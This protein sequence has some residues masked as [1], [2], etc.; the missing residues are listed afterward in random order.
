MLRTLRARLILSH[1]LPT[2]IIVPLIGILLVFILETQVLRPALAREMLGEARILAEIG[3]FQPEI[4]QDAAIA[5]Q[6]LSQ[7]R[8]Q[9][10]S[11]MMIL[12]ADGRLL[13]S[14]EALDGERIGQVLDSPGLDE[15]RAGETVD[16]ID[17][18]EGLQ[19]QAID[20]WVPVFGDGNALV[21]IIRISYRFT[22]IIE[23]LMRLRYLI[24]GVLLVGM[25]GGAFLGYVLAISLNEP[26][27][28]VTFTIYNLARGDFRQP[29]P[30]QGPEE[31]RLQLQAVNFLVARLHELEESRKQLLA[32][33]VHELGRP[34]GALRV[35]LQAL[36]RGARDDPALR[37]ELL[38]SMDLEMERLQYLLEELSHLHDQVLGSLELNLQPLVLSDWLPKVLRPWRELAEE[39]N[40]TWQMDV[41]A[42]LPPIYAD[43]QRLAQALGNLVSNAI[44]YTPVGGA[45]T[46]NAGSAN[47]EI[48]IRVA[49]TG[50]GMSTEEQ[51]HVFEPF[52]RGGETRR[53][54]QGMGL[55][56]SITQSLVAAHDGRIELQ[57]APGAGSRF[58]I[59]LPYNQ[60]AKKALAI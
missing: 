20:V 51:A 42:D 52:F 28:R 40:Q 4:W 30:E 56:L 58:T 5:Q 43:A 59:W 55:G 26:I 38:E 19:G 10:P 12:A 46:V 24:G 49:D 13:A 41:P 32:N 34:L 15:I 35:G 53:I 9:R 17:F 6:V 23:E 22:S 21:G 33:M 44:K 7:T 29:L 25:V 47:R 2:L 27:R 14:T 31:I 54:K 45:V 50:P 48:W 39:K 60:P 1:I 37:D 36:L 11:R 3:Q 18:S 16:F 8:Q 57:S